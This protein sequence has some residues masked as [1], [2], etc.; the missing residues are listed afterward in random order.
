MVALWIGMLF[1][2]RLVRF[3]VIQLK[4]VPDSIDEFTLTDEQLA[5]G[6]TTGVEV[7]ITRAIRNFTY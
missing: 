5:N 6:N 2:K 7:R 4:D 1:I 3:L